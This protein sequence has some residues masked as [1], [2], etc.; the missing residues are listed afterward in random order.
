MTD[1][2]EKH[3]DLLV[4]SLGLDRSKTP[5]RNYFA[6]EEGHFEFQELEELVEAGYMRK[7]KHP[8]GPGFIFTVT[9][10]GKQ[11]IGLDSEVNEDAQ[12]AEE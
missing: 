12:E 3:L 1:I 2:T 6:A 8:M 11:L 4:H 5:Y 7:T 9:E 10:D